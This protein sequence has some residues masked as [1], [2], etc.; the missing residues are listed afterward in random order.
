MFWF[1]KTPWA[2][3]L[4]ALCTVTLNG[5]VA[6]AGRKNVMNNLN[7]LMFQKFSL[8]PSTSVVGTNAASLGQSTEHLFSYVPA[9]ILSSV[10][11]GSALPVSPL[12]ILP[13]LNAGAALSAAAATINAEVPV[14]Y[15]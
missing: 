10:T 8:T 14:S 15:K 7:P 3:F 12:P 2:L 5:N 13:A 1:R 9:P 11:G 6:D 4:G